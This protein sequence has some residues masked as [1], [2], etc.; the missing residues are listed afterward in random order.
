MKNWQPKPGEVFVNPKAMSLG[1]LNDLIP[2]FGLSKNRERD[3]RSAIKCIARA[4]DRPIDQIHLDPEWLWAQ[5]D[6]VMPAALGIEHKTWQNTRSNLRS[7]MKL[8]G[9]G[10]RIAPVQMDGA[11]E[12]L[13]Q[14]M[15]A[16]GNKSIICW[17]GK[18]LR[19]GYLT[20]RN[21]SDV[22][23]ATILAYEDELRA[24]LHKN[25]S[26]AAYYAAHM[27][28]RASGRVAGWPANKF[29]WVDRRN[30]YCLP[31]SAFPGSLAVDIEVWLAQ[32]ADE[33]I[34]E[35]WNPGARRKPITREKRRYE[36]QRFA[37]ALAHAGVDAAEL[38]S[39]AALVDME[40]VKR[41]L[42]WLR[43]ER[44][45]G[46]LTGG[47]HNITIALANAGRRHVRVDPS[48]QARLNKIAKRCA[49]NERGMTLKN[50]MRMEPFKDPNLIRKYLD[51]PEKMFG[52]LS[53][54]PNAKRAA[55]RAETA[56]A[57]A[58]LS[59]CPIRI[60]NLCT[61]EMDR[62]LIRAR[63]GREQTVYLVIPE[64]QVKNSVAIKFE[65]P[66]V[67]IDL[68]DRFIADHRPLLA[69][70]GS[71]FLFPRR[72]ADAPIDYNSLALRIKN[73]LRS[74]LGVE[75]SSHN[76]RHLAGLIWLLENPIGFEV[77]RRLLGHK[78]ASTAMDFYV[79]LQTDA[80]HRAFT[81]LLKIYRNKKN[82]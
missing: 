41:G 53:K 18:F 33:D 59:W 38:T 4:L 7:A 13:R 82:G 9:V 77:V 72:T 63:H 8:I 56:L 52:E 21:P 65:L 19:Y 10:K 15:V 42:R 54:Q 60:G 48:H 57:V 1:Q 16:H 76:F 29:G 81:G 37:S 31:W 43:D 46:K 34:F 27:W 51:L 58:M 2:S 25:P 22:N 50:R 55:V 64:G 75:F 62:H 32:A 3:L 12:E 71:R 67:V 70:R 35:D 5:L 40:N 74:E 61:I 36:L 17:L 80:A 28:D 11:W 39:I 49:P 6:R 73:M 26:K 44:F 14:R 30:I 23:L 20:G 24:R 66:Q 68:L 47:L 79:G 45:G 69:P 78:A